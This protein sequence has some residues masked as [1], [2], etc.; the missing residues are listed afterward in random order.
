MELV[1]IS[2]IE[3]YGEL[4]LKK[5][6]PDTAYSTASQWYPFLENT[7]LEKITNIAFTYFL[8]KREAWIFLKTERIIKGEKTP[9][10]HWRI[11]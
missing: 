1:D 7:D 9:E 11:G 2:N 10:S 5:V 3:E 4:V 8:N 6:F